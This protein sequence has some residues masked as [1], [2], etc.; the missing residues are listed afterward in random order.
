MLS[1]CKCWKYNKKYKYWYYDKGD[2]GFEWDTKAKKC[3]I[4]KKPSKEAKNE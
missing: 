1:D 2:G 4:C 3:F